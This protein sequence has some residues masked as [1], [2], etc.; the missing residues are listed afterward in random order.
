MDGDRKDGKTKKL[1]VF[2]LPQVPDVAGGGDDVVG[3]MA[4][5]GRGGNCVVGDLVSVTLLFTKRLL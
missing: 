4:Q 5:V 2:G 1:A 3:I